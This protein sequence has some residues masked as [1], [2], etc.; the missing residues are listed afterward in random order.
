MKKF[1][2]LIICSALTISFLLSPVSAS[3]ADNWPGFQDVTIGLSFGTLGKAS[4]YTTVIPSKNT[5]YCKI[6]MKLQRYYNGS[7]HTVTNGTYSR[8]GLT[9][10]GCEYYVTKGYT[11]RVHSVATIYKSKGGKKINTDTFNYKRKY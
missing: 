4:Y 8:T 11:Y 3:A 6:N 9:M 7:W 2:K 10:Y 5:Y 1:Y